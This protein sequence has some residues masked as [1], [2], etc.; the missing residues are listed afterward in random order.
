[1]R[2]VVVRYKT[3]PERSDE[4]QRLVENVFEELSEQSPEGLRYATL[5]LADDVTFVHVAFIETEDGSNPLSQSD[6]FAE[7]KRAIEDRCT[8]PPAPQD[9]TVVGSYRLFAE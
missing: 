2:K 4:N 1:M 9:A 5:R 3:K 8:E 6:A 7:F